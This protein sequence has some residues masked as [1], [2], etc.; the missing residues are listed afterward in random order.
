MSGQ[1]GALLQGIFVFLAQARYVVPSLYW[2]TGITL[3][4]FI[5]KNLG[6]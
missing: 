1:T 4:K 2:A 6:H 3:P 5:V